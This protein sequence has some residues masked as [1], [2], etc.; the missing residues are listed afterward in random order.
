M[1]PATG[2]TPGPDDLPTPP[3]ARHYG[4]TPAGPAHRPH[5][6]ELVQIR[7]D[8]FWQNVV[9][10]VL[11]SLAAAA[12]S[13]TG[14]LAASP[15]AAANSTTPDNEMFDGRM[16]VITTLGQRIPIAD[17]VPVFACSAASPGADRTLASDV[18]CSIFRIRT[19]GGEMYTLPITQIVG[20]HAMTDALAEQLEAAAQEMEE[21][22]ADG[23]KMPFGFAAY[24][25]LARSEAQGNAEDR[26]TPPE[27]ATTPDR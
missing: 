7:R 5:P 3:H 23:N 2:H 20:I 14:R 10:E 8:L 1:S 21:E 24:T 15:T 25:S 9:R 17:V 11:M 12:A 13:S 26:T 6:A 19:P 4:Q 22:D 18:Q 16:G 27:Q